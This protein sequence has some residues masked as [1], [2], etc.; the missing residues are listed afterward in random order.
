V[1]NYIDSDY[2]SQ[3]EVEI[4]KL[5]DSY[6][7]RLEVDG[8]KELVTLSSGQ[9]ARV[10]QEYE[11]IGLKFSKSNMDLQIQKCKLDTEIVELKLRHQLELQEQS[12]KLKEENTKLKEEHYQV[13]LKMKDDHY[14]DLKQ[15]MEM[16]R[17]TRA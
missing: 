1:Y 12:A 8:Y 5:C 2:L 17:T 10:K 15:L 9:V 16:M 7:S 4:S 13:V 14:A 6:E 11:L 3:A